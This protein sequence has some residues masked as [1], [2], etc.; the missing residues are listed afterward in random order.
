LTH[1][2]LPKSREIICDAVSQKRD[3]TRTTDIRRSFIADLNRRIQKLK[4]Y[5]R[6]AVDIG[7]YLGLRRPNAMSQLTGGSPQ[8]VLQAFSNWVSAATRSTLLAKDGL[9]MR[10]HIE[11][12]WQRGL[13][14]AQSS[15]KQQVQTHPRA[16][17]A[18][19]HVAQSDLSAIVTAAEQNALRAVS[20]SLARRDS[21][22]KDIAKA[23]GRS[24]DKIIGERGKLLVNT[25][26]VS[27][28]S[29]A[30]LDVAEAVGITHV[31]RVPEHLPSRIVQDTRARYVRWLTAGDDRVCKIC[32]Q[33]EGD[34]LKISEARRSIPVHP[35]CRCAWELLS[36]SDL[37]EM[38][39]D[40]YDQTPTAYK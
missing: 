36:A 22:P 24:F 40:L 19:V 10:P 18:H 2:A 32:A 16:Y 13:T 28:H 23:L 3:P 11:R 38:G 25:H 9:W 29:E 31:R 27:A 21:R 30:T 14:H 17:M 5:T 33:R 37:I 12:A 26:V 8:A 34:I 6:E 20:V 1:G 7:D 39:V 35:N 4:S 15:I